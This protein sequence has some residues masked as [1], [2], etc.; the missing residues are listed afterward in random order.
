MEVFTMWKEMIFFYLTMHQI[1]C[2][3][4]FKKATITLR[5]NGDRTM[6]N[7]N[8]IRKYCLSFNNSME[9]EEKQHGVRF[10]VTNMVYRA[11]QKIDSIDA[12]VYLCDV[13]KEGYI[14]EVNL[15]HQ[16]R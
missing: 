1:W 11:I 9:V 12:Y 13:K 7:L 16:Y 14:I 4:V 10:M 15:L 3:T 8:E 6:K 5:R 2:I